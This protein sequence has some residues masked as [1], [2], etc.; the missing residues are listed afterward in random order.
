MNVSP[1]IIVMSQESNEAQTACWTFSHVA[2]WEAPTLSHQSTSVM[3]TP[4]MRR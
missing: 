4:P 1:L 2:G 3:V